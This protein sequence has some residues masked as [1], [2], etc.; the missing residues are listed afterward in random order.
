MLTEKTDATPAP[1]VHHNPKPGS[2]DDL[3]CY[4]EGEWVPMRDAKV[5]VMCWIPLGM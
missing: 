2:L 1:S 5:S 4:F 3:V